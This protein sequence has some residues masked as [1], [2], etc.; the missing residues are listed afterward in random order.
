VPGTFVGGGAQ[1]DD[2]DLRAVGGQGGLAGERVGVDRLLVAGGV[3]Q[4]GWCGGGQPVQT[5]SS[6]LSS[7]A[8]APVGW[9][10]NSWRP[11]LASSWCSVSGGAVEQLLAGVVAVQEA[12][13]GA[14]YGGRNTAAAGAGQPQS[15]NLATFA[16][17]RVTNAGSVPSSLT[18]TR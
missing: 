8:R 11:R 7:A 13:P 16:Q 6:V 9:W 12:L 17:L 1:V 18:G 2:R 15:V 3:V 4:P 5:L 10:R 14:G